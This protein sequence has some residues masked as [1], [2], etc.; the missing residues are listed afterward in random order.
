MLGDI[1][2]HQPKVNQLA[3]H[4]HPVLVTLFPADAVYR[5]LIVAHLTDA[6]IVGAT[7]DF[8]HVTHPEA[9]VDPINSGERLTGVH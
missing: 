8:H 1:L 3:D 4:A 2:R 7:Q 9:L 5:E 6:L